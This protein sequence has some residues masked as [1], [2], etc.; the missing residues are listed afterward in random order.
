MPSKTLPCDKYISTSKAASILSVSRSTILR[1]LT[2]GK[3][4]F[5]FWETPGGHY[6][7]SEQDVFVT[8][9]VREDCALECYR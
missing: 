3:S 6:R 5:I 7:I 4:P 9:A 1:L 2:S 8:K